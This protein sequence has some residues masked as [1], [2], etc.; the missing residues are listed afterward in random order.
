MKFSFATLVVI[1]GLVVAAPV[2]EPENHEGKGCSEGESCI[3]GTCQWLFCDA[4]CW[5]NDTRKPC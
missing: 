4:N 1:A 2:A 3:S 5:W